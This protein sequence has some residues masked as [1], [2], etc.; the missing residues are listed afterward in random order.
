VSKAKKIDFYHQIQP[1][2]QMNSS[3]NMKDLIARKNITLT[4][5]KNS[6]KKHTVEMTELIAKL[7]F[8]KDEDAHLNEKIKEK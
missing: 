1:E 2:K 7:D 4:A 5:L 6:R 3:K 8:L